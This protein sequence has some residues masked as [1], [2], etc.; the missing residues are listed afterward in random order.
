MQGIKCVKRNH[1]QK[2]NKTSTHLFIHLFICVPFSVEFLFHWS[3]EIP[4]KVG[5]Q[6]GNNPVGIKFER[7]SVLPSKQQFL[8][9]AVTKIN[10]S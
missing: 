10:V 5:I 4:V 6:Q 9:K 3:R 1:T 7:G 8:N 2:L